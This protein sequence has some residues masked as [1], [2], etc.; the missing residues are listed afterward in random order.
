MLGGIEGKLKNA[1]RLLLEF[2]SEE[3]KLGLKEVEFYKMV[4]KIL[5]VNSKN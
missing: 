2:V 3:S 1:S 4:E 5:E